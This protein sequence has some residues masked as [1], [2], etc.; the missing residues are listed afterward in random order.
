VKSGR[1]A[2]D[3]YAEY[4][5][6]DIDFVQGDDAVAALRMQETIVIDYFDSFTEEAANG[7]TYA[8]GKWTLKQVLGHL[9]D[10]ER[11]FQYRALCIARGDER[12]LA[13]FDENDYMAASNFESRTIEDLLAEYRAVRHAT[14]TLFAGLPEEAWSRRGSAN[15]HE[16]T[17]RGLAFH[18][19]GHELH[20]LRILRER[21]GRK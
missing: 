12:P 6:S 8:Q 15:G 17:V 21:Y 3:E 4:A 2:E 5:K 18:I 11:V 1:P 9:V 13:G 19:A 7:L 10:D 16:V 14:V 20:H